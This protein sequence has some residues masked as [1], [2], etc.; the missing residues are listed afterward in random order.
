MPESNGSISLSAW[1]TISRIGRSGCCALTKSSRRR[2][3]NK[4]SVKVSA[5]R[6]ISF[7]FSAI[8]VNLYN[9]SARHFVDRMGEYF[10]SLLPIPRPTEIPFADLLDGLQLCQKTENLEGLN[11][12]RIRLQYMDKR[13]AQ[14]QDQPN[15]AHRG[16]KHLGGHIRCR[17]DHLRYDEV[18]AECSDRP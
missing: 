7:V 15:P 5:P 17:K 1:F 6:M 3:V 11:P 10:S 12:L 2:I 4:L 9:A 14:I 18:E 13:T 8:S 16:T